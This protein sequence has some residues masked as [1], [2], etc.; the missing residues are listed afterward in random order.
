M[1]HFVVQ[2]GKCPRKTWK[3]MFKTKLL[4]THKEIHKEKQ[5]HHSSLHTSNKLTKNS[6]IR[7]KLQELYIVTIY[8]VKSD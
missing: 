2:I 7:R 8:L 4:T 6:F 1:L 3:F 5:T